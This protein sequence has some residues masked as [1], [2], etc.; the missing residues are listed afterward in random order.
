MGSQQN[1]RNISHLRNESKG[2]P[3]GV[4]SR[5]P[6]HFSNSLPST[7]ESKKD[8]KKYV[9][10]PSLPRKDIVIQLKSEIE[11]DILRF[12][13]EIKVLKRNQNIVETL[14]SP[15]EE[16]P[17][18]SLGIREI[19]GF[20][21]PFNIIDSVIEHN[22]KSSALA[23]KE[24]AINH[25]QNIYN[26]SHAPHS[27][28][29][30]GNHQQL[31]SLMY[32][33]IYYSQQIIKEKGECLAQEYIAIKDAWKQQCDV[34]DSINDQ[35]HDNSFDWPE[36]MVVPS[37]TAPKESSLTRYS[38]PD[39]PMSHFVN[40]LDSDCLL[41]DQMQIHDPIASHIQ[42]KERLTWSEEEKSIF[43]SRFLVNPKEFERIASYLPNK[44]VK[45]VIEFYYLS[46]TD[47]DLL[48]V[49]EKPN[50]RIKRQKSDGNIKIE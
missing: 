9:T 23:H 13:D 2:F 25:K 29:S 48:S 40:Q 17:A 49:D 33:S 37:K 5:M 44:S 35:N 6:G 36:E 1:T 50:K 4:N 19:D 30:I 32:T 7:N 38:A 41:F 47:L 22:R 24:S 3:D 26:A 39:V 20:I 31:L 45:D 10:N 42:F 46:K 16:I 18:N 15:K 21:V 8:T 27:L 34:I 12:N 28:K 11:H 43:V 14:F